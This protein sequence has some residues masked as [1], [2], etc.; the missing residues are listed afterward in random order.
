[1]LYYCNYAIATIQK[2]N[3]F[4]TSTSTE[5]IKRL[6]IKLHECVLAFV[7]R[8]AFVSTEYIMMHTSY[9]TYVHRSSACPKYVSVYENDVMT[10]IAI[11]YVN[12]YQHQSSICDVR[13]NFSII[14]RG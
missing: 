14:S 8:N 6:I 13:I 7:L 1:M 10:Y 5:L 2:N 12:S 3:N 11:L 4:T 9:S